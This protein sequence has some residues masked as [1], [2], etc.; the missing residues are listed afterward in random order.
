MANTS[1][2][3]RVLSPVGG[4]GSGRRRPT[5]RG[6]AR[7]GRVVSLDAARGL[8]VL[9][10]VFWLA[11]PRRPFPGSG[12]WGAIGIDAI[13][14]PAFAVVLGCAFA[15]AQHRSWSTA[16]RVI[17][18]TLILL[19][20]GLLIAAGAALIAG[21]ASG[22]PVDPEAGTLGGLERIRVAGP[23]LQLG[24][25]AAALGLLGVLARSWAGWAFAV[26]LATGVGAGALWLATGLC[27]ELSDRCSPATL[28]V[29]GVADAAGSTADP[30]I[31]VAVTTVVAGLGLALPAAAG[32]ALVHA[33][34][35]A[36]SVSGH[37][38][39]RVI[40]Y[41]LLAA[42]LFGILGVLAFFTPTVWGQ[43]ALQPATALW[44]PPLTLFV[45]T[46]A[47]LLATA[48]HPAIDTDLRGGTSALGV[49]AQPFA[50]VGRIS[51]LAVGATLAA[52]TLLDALSPSPVEWFARLGDI[53]S[54]A[55]GG[56]VV[57]LWLAVA[58]W[59]ERS[60]RRLRP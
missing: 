10:T 50:A 60:G 22:V 53:P 13:V 54:I 36:R 19:L 14:L 43:Q 41:G 55:L 59:A 47:G 2:T 48:M 24:V 33:F 3:T 32:A 1:A 34:L 40:G 25:A 56:I 46:L 11:A 37:Q 12:P 5:R 9:A 45:A 39:G 16:G 29:T 8:L 58:Q 27:G 15:M 17:R 26:V 35:R 20:I 30:L 4:S 6:A 28:I 42:L 49:F 7:I 38:R 18:R 31:I 23:L 52:R 21:A 57:A 44:T 51:L